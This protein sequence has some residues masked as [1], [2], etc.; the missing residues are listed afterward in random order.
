MVSVGWKWP[1][2]RVQQDLPGDR[3]AEVE[4]VRADDIGLG[5]EA[6]QLALHGV[7]VVAAVD[8]LGKDLVQ[9]IQQQ[10]RG[11]LPIHRGILDPIGD[12]DVVD[13]RRAQLS[14]HVL[15]D[16]PAGDAVLDPE[17][18]DAGVVAG[19]CHAARSQRMVEQ[20]GVEVEPVALL[21]G[22]ADPV[23]EMRGLQLV[24]CHTGATRLGVDGVQRQPVP[25]GD[26][27]VGL[28]QVAAQLSGVRAL[29]G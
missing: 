29:P 24:A 3:V 6:E 25:A 8:G 20:G 4:L 16:L 9:R 12:P 14:P 1:L 17:L 2:S 22:P 26:Q 27:G 23:V 18:P 11:R 19:K 7:Q 10:R 15:A 5:T 21:L 13:A 28:V